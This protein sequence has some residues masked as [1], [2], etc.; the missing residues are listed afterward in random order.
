MQPKNNRGF[1]IVETMIAVAVFTFIAGI[2]TVVTIQLSKSYQQGI[3]RSKL[4]TAKKY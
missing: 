4:D 1:T 3:I 2:A